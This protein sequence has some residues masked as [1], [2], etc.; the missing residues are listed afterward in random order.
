MR[1]LDSDHE[2]HETI[3]SLTIPHADDLNAWRYG[4]YVGSINETRCQMNPNDTEITFFAWNVLFDASN[5]WQED[6]LQ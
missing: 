1:S 4:I 3:T 5:E 2:E 6:Q